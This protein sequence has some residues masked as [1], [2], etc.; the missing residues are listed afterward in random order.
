[1][2]SGGFTVVSVTL[3]YYLINNIVFIIGLILVSDYSLCKEKFCT[4]S[5]YWDLGDT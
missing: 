4:S 5:S 3:E 2:D 1:M